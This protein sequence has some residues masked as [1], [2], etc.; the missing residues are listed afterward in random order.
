MDVDEFD[1]LIAESCRP[2]ENLVFA[3]L[4][5]G[6]PQRLTLRF[7]SNDG[8]GI[9]SKVHGYA[10][11]HDDLREVTGASHHEKAA[12]ILLQFSNI[13]RSGQLVNFR[14]AWRTYWSYRA[15]QF[16]G[17]HGYLPIDVLKTLPDRS[18]QIQLK[19]DFESRDLIDIQLSRRFKDL[20]NV[21]AMAGDFRR[22]D[23]V[24]VFPGSTKFK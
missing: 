21:S 12:I 10:R 17:N 14:R 4:L 23:S 11:Y 2:G 1:R 18:L 19:F 3:M 24:N 16:A 7:V 20:T 15:E 6:A 8:V 22:V 9:I 5:Q 13:I